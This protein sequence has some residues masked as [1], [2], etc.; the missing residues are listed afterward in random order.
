MLPGTRYSSVVRK[1]EATKNDTMNIS[2]DEFVAGFER[3][4]DNLHETI[5]SWDSLEPVIADNYIEDIVWMLSIRG[6]VI[7]KAS[8]EG[9]GYGEVEGRIN[10]ALL[11]FVRFHDQL[12][13]Q[14]GIP[15]E[16]FVSAT[17]LSKFALQAPELDDVVNYAMAA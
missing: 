3:S 7:R 5:S 15:S 8:A 17:S 1:L 13:E 6:D 14:L 9:R 11:Q 2:T 10:N 4:A 12:V 16:L